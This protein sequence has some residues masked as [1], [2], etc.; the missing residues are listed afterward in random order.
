[1]SSPSVAII[2][3]GVG[4]LLSV[5]RA[6]EYLDVKVVITREPDVILSASH[7]ILPG[8]GA[9][10]SAMAALKHLELIDIIQSLAFKDIPLLGICLGMQLLFSESEEFGLTAGLNLIPGKVIPIPRTTMDGCQHKLPHIGWAPLCSH[11]GV[12]W[13]GTLL[14]SLKPN[15]AVYFIHSYRAVPEE[16][17]Y[18]LATCNYGGHPI[19][20]V[21][22]KNNLMGCQFHPEK[23][24]RVG[25]NILKDFLRT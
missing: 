25:L 8:V 20:V 10:A 17:K 6:F 2:D 16:A 14:A 15:D 24:G 22:K 11:E 9:F 5:A 1:M 13:K 4:N 23:S 7:V 18:C 12:D 3:Y 19:N 21:V